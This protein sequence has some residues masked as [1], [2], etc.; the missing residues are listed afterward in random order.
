M[1]GLRCST[2]LGELLK[3]PNHVSTPK[4]GFPNTGGALFPVLPEYSS[5]DKMPFQV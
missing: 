4:K 1:S 2:P 5:G 3:V